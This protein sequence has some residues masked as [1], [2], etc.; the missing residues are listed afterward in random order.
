MDERPMEPHH[1]TLCPREL[2]EVEAQLW[3]WAPGSA[4]HPKVLSADPTVPSGLPEWPSQLASRVT[5]AN[6]TGFRGKGLLFLQ[7]T[8]K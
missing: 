8:S 1:C 6:K 5:L 3:G 4:D 2:L 7:R